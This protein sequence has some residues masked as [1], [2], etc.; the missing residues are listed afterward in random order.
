[1]KY[2]IT[3]KVTMDRCLNNIITFPY[4]CIAL[5]EFVKFHSRLNV[6]SIQTFL[7]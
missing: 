3:K 6:N 5:W 2:I 7:H 4:I 1:M